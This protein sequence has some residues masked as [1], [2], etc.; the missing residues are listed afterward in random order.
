MSTDPATAPVV[1]D[2]GPQP[3][4]YRVAGREYVN[5]AWIMEEARHFSYSPVAITASPAE[6]DR[7]LRLAKA[8]AQLAAAIEGAVEH[9]VTLI[10]EPGD[11]VASAENLY[12]LTKP[13]KR[14]HVE[15]S[16]VRAAYPVDEFGY[17][18]KPTPDAKAIR[19]HLPLNEHPDLYRT[20][21]SPPSVKVQPLSPLPKR[22]A[23]R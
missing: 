2:D 21:E 4:I 19:Q 7:A 12:S 14:T 22:D 8:L 1:A 5:P 11:R 16:K 18:Y 13:G 15:L 23:D 10:V 6:W 3:T 9:S 20:T 17:L